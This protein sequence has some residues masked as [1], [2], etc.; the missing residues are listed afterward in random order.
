MIIRLAQMPYLSLAVL[1]ALG[2]PLFSGAT[3]EAGDRKFGY[4]YE[5]TTLP[6]G[7]LE[8]ESWVTW[9]SFGNGDRF[10]FRHELEYGVTDDFQVSLYMANWRHEDRG[11]E[12]DS[13]FKSTSVEAI[14]ALTDP[15]EDFLGSALY[16][17]AGL[18]D[19]EVFVEGKLLLQ[20]N[21]GRWIV[22][23]NS[24]VEP[25]WE[26]DGARESSR[27]EGGTGADSRGKLSV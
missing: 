14:H 6:K 20:K 2:A 9:K 25:E 27:E 19:E 11:G 3:A 12:T 8:F 1:T 4:T 21:F 17:E 18:G 22:A 5:A 24:V 26:G 10:D 23:G 15:T 16:L 13:A 7:A